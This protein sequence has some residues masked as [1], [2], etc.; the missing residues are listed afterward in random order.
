MF[1]ELQDSSNH[2]NITIKDSYFGLNKVF[3]EILGLMGTSGGG[4]MLD[5]N[6]FNNDNQILYNSVAFINTVFESNFAFNGGGFSFHSSE[7]NGVIQPTNHL[8]F[9]KCYWHK[10]EAR[11]GAAVDLSIWHSAENGQLVKP[12]FGSCRFESNT[13]SGYKIS[14]TLGKY[15]VTDAGSSAFSGGYWPGIGIMYLD[16]ITVDFSAVFLTTQAALS[17]LLVLGSTC[18]P[19]LLLILQIILVK[20]VVHCI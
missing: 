19:M 4:A 10:N 18:I 16:G 5:Y 8:R 17:Q 15:V 1:I 7:E 2:N 6:I 14:D 12:L 20:W 9:T 3:P 13:A 11:L